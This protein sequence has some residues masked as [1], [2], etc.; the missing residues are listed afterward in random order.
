VFIPSLTGAAGAPAE[1]ARFFVFGEARAPGAYA[2]SPNMHLSQAVAMAGGL[3][4]SGL[5]ESV[6][7][8]RGG[9]DKP[10]IIEANFQ[11]LLVDGDRRQDVALQPGDIV[12]IPRTGIANWNAFLAQ[13]RP[14]LEFLTLTTATVS[15]GQSILLNQ[16]TIDRGPAFR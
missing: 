2:Y 7:V 14:T 3:A 12:M 8:I 6:R 9:L 1:Q 13:V 4:D 15:S 10:E 11:K 16:R 5:A